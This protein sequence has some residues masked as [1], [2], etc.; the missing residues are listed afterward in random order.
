MNEETF[1]K[2][3]F[4]KAPREGAPDFVKGHINIKREEAIEWLM[5]LDREWV[6]TDLLAKKDG[7]GLYLK[8]NDFKPKAKEDL[9]F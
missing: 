9:P 2:G 1:P 4:Y 5:S 3:I 7:S 6:N 8:I